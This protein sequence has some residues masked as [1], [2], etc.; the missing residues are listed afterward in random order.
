MD[1]QRFELWLPEYLSG[2]L[3]PTQQAEMQA[4]LAQNAGAR[5]RLAA[6]REIREQLGGERPQPPAG[7]L[8]NYHRALAENLAREVAR[9]PRTRKFRLGRPRWVPAGFL[10]AVLMLLMAGWYSG[11]RVGVGSGGGEAAFQAQILAFPIL[12]N[13]TR[14]IGAFLSES[15][16]LL[17]SL[18]HVPGDPI[19]SGE[20]WQ[21]FRQMAVSLLGKS[22]ELRRVAVEAGDYQLLQLLTR[23]EVLFYQIANSAEGERN[24]SLALIRDMIGDLNMLFDLRNL[25]RVF[26]PSPDQMPA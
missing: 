13:D 18:M 14:Q 2:E 20:E 11:Y 6:F 9:H 8:E 16:L 12:K 24:A 26:K 3:D 19:L 1:Q 7:F 21:T 5:Q 22:P 17:L 15:E 25:Q 23:L 10:A 4:W